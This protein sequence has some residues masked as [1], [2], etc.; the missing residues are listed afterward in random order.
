MFKKIRVLIGAAI[1]LIPGML[2]AHSY[3]GGGFSAKH[4]S[5]GSTMGQR[6][7]GITKKCCGT[8]L[9]GYSS[10]GRQKG[11]NHHGCGL[12]ARAHIT[13]PFLG[14]YHHSVDNNGFYYGHSDYSPVYVG[15]NPVLAGNTNRAGCSSCND[16]YSYYRWRA[17]RGNSNVDCYQ[18]NYSGCLLNNYHCHWD[19]YRDNCQPR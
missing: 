5:C 10:T 1:F 7:G 8:Q 13:L 17:S 12:L 19:N 6:C 2:S 3:H 18:K 11:N 15:Y 16:N 4:Q 9:S 14:H